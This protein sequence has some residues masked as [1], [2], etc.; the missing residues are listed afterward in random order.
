MASDG[1]QVWVENMLRRSMAPC[2][3]KQKLSKITAV[4]AKRQRKQ[5]RCHWLI[6]RTVM[7]W[8]ERPEI[9]L[10]HLNSVDSFENYCFNLEKRL[11]IDCSEFN[12]PVSDRFFSTFSI[13]KSI[14]I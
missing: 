6:F 5:S 11:L 3:E 2:A 9:D 7:Q 8:L 14:K 13:S 10:V 4:M 12:L 1:F